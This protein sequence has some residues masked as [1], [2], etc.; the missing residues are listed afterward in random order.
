LYDALPADA[1][2]CSS[3]LKLLWLPLESPVDG[4]VVGKGIEVACVVAVGT[5][6][7]D[8]AVVGF[9]VPGTTVTIVT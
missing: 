5:P 2:A 1:A 6:G 7:D 3:A 8:A 9:L 4:A